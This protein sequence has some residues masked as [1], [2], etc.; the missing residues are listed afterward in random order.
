MQ[1]LQNFSCRCRLS[2]NHVIVSSVDCVRLEVVIF[3]V[4]G[5]V[6]G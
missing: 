5:R 6:A 1:S 3:W 4:N 2:I